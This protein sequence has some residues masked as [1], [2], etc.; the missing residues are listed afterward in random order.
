[1]LTIEEYIEKRKQEDELNEF[2]LDKRLENIK[3]CIDYIFE[4]YNNYLDISEIDQKTILNNERLNKYRKQLSKYS[5]NIKDWLV[6]TY[7][8]HGNCMNK[9]I[10]NILD[11][12][13]LFLAMSTDGEFRSISYEYYSGL[14]KKYPYLK[15]QAEMIFLFIKDYHRMKSD[16]EFRAPFLSDKITAW[17]EDTMEKHGVNIETFVYSYLNKFFDNDDMWPRTHKKK[18]ENSYRKY[19]YDYTKKTN[20]FGIDLLYPKISNKPYIKGKKQYIEIL[21]MY[22]WLKEFYGDNGYWDKYLDMIFPK[23]KD[24]ND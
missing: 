6:D 9:I 14:I 3:S 24:S 1:M 4:Y 11:E 17:L 23:D 2:D 19:E 12:N 10:G 22:F 8:K 18:V 16:E 20:L 13:E 7:D 21:M 15:S 5:D